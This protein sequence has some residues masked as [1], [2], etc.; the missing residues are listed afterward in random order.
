MEFQF[1]KSYGRLLGV[2]YTALYRRLAKHLKEKQ[3]PI[4]PDQ[5]RVL[6][7][8]WQ[9]DGCSQ[10][11]LA[12]GSNRDKANIT[13]IIDILEREGL[14]K[15]VQHESDR[16]VYKVSLTQKGKDLEKDASECAKA[17]IEE[18]LKGVTKE[19]LEA[20]FR[21]LNKTIEN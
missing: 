7:H 5:F 6:T 20:C 8:L 15:R 1:S 13:R 18:S 19:D 4:T 9:N 2:A 10:Q 12:S 16:R 17:A 11:E 14:V 21:V 3:L